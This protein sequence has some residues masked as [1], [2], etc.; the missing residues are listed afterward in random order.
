VEN[1]ELPADEGMLGPMIRII[2]FGI[3][4]Q[5]LGLVPA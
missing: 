1:G 4:R 5:Y 2:C 3:V